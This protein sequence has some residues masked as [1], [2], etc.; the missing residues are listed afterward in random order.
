MELPEG[1]STVVTKARHCSLHLEPH[2]SSQHPRTLFLLRSILIL[3]MA[4][5][6]ALL[7]SGYWIKQG[8]RGSVVG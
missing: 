7:H 3:S 8:A 5:I 4:D 6:T 1:F 2:E